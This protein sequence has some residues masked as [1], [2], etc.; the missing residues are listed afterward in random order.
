L[1]TRE[2]GGSLRRHTILFRNSHHSD[3]LEVE[4]SRR[5]IP[6]VKYGGL[7]FL[8]A[9]HIKDLLAVLRWADNPRNTL[10]AFRVLQ[11][12]PGMGPVNARKCIDLLESEAGSL[13]ALARYSAPQAAQADFGKLVELLRALAKPE[14]PWAGQIRQ[15]RDWYRPHLE[16]LY[17]P[18]HTRLGD[19]DQLEQL[20]THYP[21]RERFIS[22][23]TLD[24]PQ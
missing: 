22:E 7:K 20:S 10:A 14:H 1:Q 16:R 23:L 3:V 4:L 8:E 15:V 12:L 9:A 11:L 5:N 19:L 6:F 13:E 2:I 24:P 17:E 21:S 18:A